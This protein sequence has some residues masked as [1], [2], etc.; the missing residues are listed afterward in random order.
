[1]FDRLSLRRCAR[2]FFSLLA[3]LWAAN[4]FMGAADCAAASA[5]VPVPAF[6]SI[7]LSTILLG[8]IAHAM[9]RILRRLGGYVCATLASA[10]LPAR[11]SWALKTCP[12]VLHRHL[13]VDRPEL[14][15]PGVAR[16]FSLGLNAI[17]SSPPHPRHIRF[18]MI[19]LILIVTSILHV[20]TL[21]V[22]S[23]MP[24][25]YSGMLPC[26]LGGFLSR[27]VSSISSA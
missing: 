15:A 23:N 26:F 12:Q 27:L 11:S 6:S 17:A 7:G 24:R 4:L 8:S 18:C 9:C 14:P 22:W 2:F 21:P 5:C 3:F 10:R 16:A 1:V 20:A 13:E 25:A 19:G